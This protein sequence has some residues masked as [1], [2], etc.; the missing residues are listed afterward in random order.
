[1]S[2]IQDGVD[3]MLVDP[4]DDQGAQ[5]SD[6]ARLLVLDVIQTIFQQA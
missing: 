4:A 3:E 5:A 1:M 6:V 2:I